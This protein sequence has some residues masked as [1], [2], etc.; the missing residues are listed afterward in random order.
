MRL[1]RR[2]FCAMDQGSPPMFQWK[3]A[4]ALLVVLVVGV[5]LGSVLGPATG[6]RAI[7][8][9]H[10]GLFHGPPTIG[11]LRSSGEADS[12]CVESHNAHG[13]LVH[14]I[15]RDSGDLPAA[16]KPGPCP[17]IHWGPIGWSGPTGH[18]GVTGIV[19][20]ESIVAPAGAVGPTGDTDTG[21]VDS[22][23]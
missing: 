9:V 11:T 5:T 3:V 4:L 13:Q 6:N 7:V 23:P 10:R 19:A 12:F 1:R 22:G 8:A 20:P 14:V 2:M 21:P 16:I 18:I 15:R 17:L